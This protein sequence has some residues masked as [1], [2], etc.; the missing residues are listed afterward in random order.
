MRTRLD[1]PVRHRPRPAATLSL[2]AA[3]ALLAACSAER[4][5]DLSDGEPLRVLTRNA[6]TTWYRGAQGDRGPEHDLAQSF[7]RH[8]GVPVEFVILDS[9]EEIL[10]AIADNR[11][12][13]AAAGLTRTEVRL[14]AGFVFGPPYHS[15]TQQVVCRRGGTIPEDVAGLIGRDI[16]VIAGSSYDERLLELKADHPDLQWSTIPGVGTE[17]L[18]AR[19]WNEKIDCTVADSNIV[20]I[21]RRYHPEL[22]VAFDLTEPQP[23]AWVLS[24][25]WSTLAD[26]IR[27][28]LTIIED[29]GERAVIRDRYYGHVASFDYVDVSVFT[30]RI[31][32]RLPRYRSL[33]EDAAEDFDLPWTLLAAQAYQESH[34]DP[35]ATSPTGVRGIMMLSE[36]TA[37]S[38]EVSD[39]L[40]PA[41]SIFGGARYLSRML[42]RIPDEVEEADRIWFALVAYNIGFAHLRDALTLA[43][44]LGR[45]PNRWVDLK[46][47]LP[48]LSRREYY[49][50][51]EYG[52]ARGEEPVAYISR[53][54]DYRS[55]LQKS[56]E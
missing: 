40:D 16:A 6:P 19:V 27:Q 22:E 54:R 25:E 42:D 12:H 1:V 17:S 55:L 15:V 18:L 30:R 7:A 39:R 21:N 11:G 5:G 2:L 48:L 10:E 26:D 9:I 32:E 3:G 34:W 29:N 35:E 43:K 41:Q 51:L 13:L 46:E 4:P 56:L 24:P 37:E 8:L 23:L 31:D 20:K 44:R 14:E 49:R 33:F 45:N 53:I 28:W 52:Y 47:V 50:D 38:L 36:R